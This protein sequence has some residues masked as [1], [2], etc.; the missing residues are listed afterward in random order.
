MKKSVLWIAAALCAVSVA[1]MLLA[2]SRGGRQEPFSPPPFDP[3]AQ[4]GTPQVPES[5]G[6]G[7][8]DAKAFRFSAAGELTVQDG[9]VDVWLTD[10]AENQVWLKVR[11][12]DEQDNIL[13]ESGL[14]RPGQYLR[15]VTLDTVPQQTA[16]VTLKVM[17]YEPETYYSAGAA[18][19]RTVL[20]I[21]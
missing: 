14:I 8:L 16:A 7:E 3:A 6:Y 9:S 2:L 15:T 13:G 10:P 19:L 20:Q 11:I 21:G 5:A 1:V 18:A 17:A 4:T 12:L